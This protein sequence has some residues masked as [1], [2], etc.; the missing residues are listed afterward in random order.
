[1]N[2]G[3]IQVDGKLPN[4]ALMKLSAFHKARGD[5]VKLIDIS[6]NNFDVVYGSKIFMGGSGYDIKQKL[7][8]GIEEMIPDYD[9]FNLDYSIGFTSRGCIRKCNF[10]IVNEKEGEFKDDSMRFIKHSKVLL[11]D[12]NF[13]ASEKCIDKLNY[14]IDNKIKVCF[15]QGLDIRLMTKE[16]AEV[17]VN[18]KYY[19]LNF[20]KRRLYFAFDDLSIEKSVIRGIDI[21]INAGVKPDHLMFYVLCGFNTNHKQDY[22][23]FKVLNDLGCLPFI[24][25]YN[26][27]GNKKLRDFSRWVNKRYYKVC[28]FDDYNTKVIE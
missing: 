15:N 17:L 27:R 10:C 22:Y 1:M 6:T 23:R 20:K 3:L 5:H 2:V 8:D 4:L 12:N 28:S 18:V 21:L 25:I 13:L 16:I 19:D 9:L 24:M 26:N 14:F 7:P 11:L